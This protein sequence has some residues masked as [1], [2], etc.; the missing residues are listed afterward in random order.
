MKIKKYSEEKNETLFSKKALSYS[1]MT[2]AFLALASQTNA[3][4]I[5]TDVIPDDTVRATAADSYDYFPIDFDNDGVLDVVIQ[6]HIDIDTLARQ[7]FV[8]TFTQVT[9]AGAPLF[10][11]ANRV[12]RIIGSKYTFTTGKV[13]QYPSVLN[14]GDVIS[15]GNPN[16][17]SFSEGYPVKYHMSLNYATGGGNHYGQWLGVEG[18]MGVEFRS[19]S[20]VHYGWVELKVDSVPNWVIVKG[21]AYES[22]PGDSIHAGELPV[23][24]K[25]IKSDGSYFMLSNNPASRNKPS[26]V[27]F[28]SDKQ[29]D[30]KLE[31]INNLGEVIQTQTGSA[32]TGKNNTIG[33]HLQHVAAGNYFVRLTLGDKV[34]HRK[35]AVA[36][37]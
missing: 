26:A 10:I 5:Y 22:T 6:H 36:E 28:S 20:D 30:Y 15:S 33:L 21:Y 34:Q 3:Q 37:N 4:V 11:L 35:L 27:I 14:F 24:V 7:A 9:S 2:G 19:G 25:N 13:Y 18:Y 31:I 8:G 12:N 16:L 1:A 23:G 17:H 32:M 29:Q